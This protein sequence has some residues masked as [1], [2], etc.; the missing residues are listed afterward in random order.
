MSSSPSPFHL[1]WSTV[2]SSR[3]RPRSSRMILSLTKEATSFA[4]AASCNNSATNLTNHLY[5]TLP[6]PAAV[7]VNRR[8]CAAF[9]VPPPHGVL[10]L[11]GCS[12]V[13]FAQAIVQNELF[14]HNCPHYGVRIREMS[15]VLDENGNV[16]RTR[17][18]ST[19]STQDLDLCSKLEPSTRDEAD[20]NLQLP[21]FAAVD[22][23]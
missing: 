16:S 12:N 7:L 15:L 5:F 10:F 6:V 13:L 20:T 11:M 23:P 14:I 21:C 22:F 1:G 19:G 4:C 17:Q 18:L 2:R 3:T 9:P 8:F